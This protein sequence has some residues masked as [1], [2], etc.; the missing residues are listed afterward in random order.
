MANSSGG[1]C[2]NFFSALSCEPEKI[3]TVLSEEFTVTQ[4]LENVRYRSIASIEIANKYG[5][6]RDKNKA[7]EILSQAGKITATLP[8]GESKCDRLDVHR[9]VRNRC[10]E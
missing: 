3:N 2:G 1:I 9:S 6:A 7:T 4:T 5:E 10:L 8:D